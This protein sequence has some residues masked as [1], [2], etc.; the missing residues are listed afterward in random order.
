MSR[1]VT[2]ILQARMTSSRLPGKVLLPVLGRPL[3]AHQL[4]RLRHARCLERVVLAPTARATDDPVAAWGQSEGLIV[5]RG[6]ELDVLDRYHGAAAACGAEVV[7]R[8]TGDCPLI[9]PA[10]CDRLAEEFFARGA[11]YAATGPRFAEGLDCEVLTREALDTS[12][13]EAR[14]PSEREHVTLFVRNHPE[15]F[16]LHVMENATDDS[17]YRLTVDEER[18]FAVVRSVLEALE[19]AGGSC[20]GTAAIKEFLDAHPEV[21]RINADIVRNEGLAKSLAE[22]AGRARERHTED[23][24]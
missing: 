1:P 16:R 3:L 17:R 4:E 12:W 5:F 11:D 14:L 15:R 20:A 13:R 10:V 19:G 23:K 18:D 8:L 24:P 22:D 9:D 7:M 6:S 2:A 21:L